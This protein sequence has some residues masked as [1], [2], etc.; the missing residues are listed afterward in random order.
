MKKDNKP[1]VIGVPY[2]TGSGG[3]RCFDGVRWHDCDRY[4]KI[5]G[6]KK[7]LN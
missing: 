5:I 7:W 1:A 4:G 6:G 3:Y 2:P